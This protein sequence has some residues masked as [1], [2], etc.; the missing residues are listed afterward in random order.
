MSVHKPLILLPDGKKS[1][2]PLGGQLA[3]TGLSAL[4]TF[5]RVVSITYHDFGL[6]TKRIDQ[7]ALESTAYPDSDILKTVFY[8]DVG[9]MN[10]RIDKVEFSGDIFGAQSLRKSF[11]YTLSGHRYVRSGFTYELF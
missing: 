10:Q 9:T 6:R 2:L 3:G 1:Q 7:V 11:S 5:E 4:A 8:L